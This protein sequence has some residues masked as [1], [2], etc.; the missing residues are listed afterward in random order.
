MTD[1]LATGS[2][3]RQSL[4]QSTLSGSNGT[5]PEAVEVSSDGVTIRAN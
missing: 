4:T 1:G 3:C 2:T 5:A